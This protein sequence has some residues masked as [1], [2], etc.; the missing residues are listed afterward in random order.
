VDEA[1]H[2]VVPDQH[3]VRP[4]LRPE[5]YL[6]S[7][8]AIAF[9]S[10]FLKF[11]ALELRLAG[12]SDD[13]ARARIS[14]H[15]ASIVALLGEYPKRYEALGPSRPSLRVRSQTATGRVQVS[16]LAAHLQTL[17]DFRQITDII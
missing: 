5:W 13:A 11:G 1:Q 9:L 6:Q 7:D 4:I 12:L 15:M 16:R 10:E 14:D 2:T 17:F 3:S 8:L